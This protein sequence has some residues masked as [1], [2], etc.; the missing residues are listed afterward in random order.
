MTSK[1]KAKAVTLLDESKS[2][3]RHPEVNPQTPGGAAHKL[4]KETAE[5]DGMVDKA[6]RA[7]EEAD[8][9]ISGEYERR[10]QPA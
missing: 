6:K 8:R 1:R 2:D 5:G 4:R 10:D 9:Q 3:E 7:I